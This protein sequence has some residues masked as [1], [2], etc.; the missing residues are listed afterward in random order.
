MDQLELESVNSKN[1]CLA[2]TV[3]KAGHHSSPSQR[4]RAV[5]KARASSSLLESLI[6]LIIPWGNSMSELPFLILILE[7]K[8][9]ETFA[10]SCTST[11]PRTESV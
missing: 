9:E 1:N 5:T 7:N 6:M 4:H 8:T 11:E 2:L 10:P 3:W